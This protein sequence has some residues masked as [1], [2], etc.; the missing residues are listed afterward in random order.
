MPAFDPPHCAAAA[1]IAAS[2]GWRGYRKKS[3]T[4]NGALSAF[5][6]GFLSFAGDIR[7]GVLLI[8]FYICGSKATKV[9]KELKET[10]DDSAGSASIRGAHQVLAC[11]ALATALTV[12]LAAIGKSEMEMDFRS[13]YAGSAATAAVLAHYACCNGD[14]LASELGILSNEQP[15]FILDGRSVPRGTNGGVTWVGLLVSAGGGTV[16]GLAQGVTEVCLIG[17]GG[18]MVG[19]HLVFGTVMVRVD[20]VP[21]GLH[22]VL[23]VYRGYSGR[24]WIRYWERCCNRRK[25]I[26]GV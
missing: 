9:K 24:C 15:W 25:W 18:A 23:T 12:G 7:S 2:L 5:T 10:L 20:D 8:T 21:C 1:L 13:D 14:T 19:R 6:V 17:V 11:S 26:H 4:F 16:I 3:L 22:E